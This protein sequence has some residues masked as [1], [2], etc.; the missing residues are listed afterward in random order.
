MDHGNA[1][2]NAK[3]AVRTPIIIICS[4]ALASILSMLPFGGTEYLSLVSVLVILAVA[5]RRAVLW[6]VVAL[7]MTASAYYAFHDYVLLRLAPGNNALD[8]AMIVAGLASYTILAWRL[9]FSGKWRMTSYVL[10]PLVAFT[11]GS[12]LVMHFFILITPLRERDLG[13]GVVM[14]TNQF[15]AGSSLALGTILGRVIARLQ[16]HMT[17]RRRHP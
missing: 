1:T 10:L 3:L 15:I 7:G 14:V 8:S 4:A 5:L 6:P 11:S 12:I 16:L 9:S 17:E 2:L 13:Y